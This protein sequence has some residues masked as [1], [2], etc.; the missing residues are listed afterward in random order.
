[1]KKRL[2]T[3]LA[4]TFGLS[5][6]VWI[7]AGFITGAV[8]DVNSS[9]IMLAIV[10]VSMFFPLVGALAAN[11]VV[12]ETER[13]DLGFKPRIRENVRSYVMAWLVP[14]ALA[15]AGSV[16]FFLVFPQLFDRS[17]TTLKAMLAAEGIPE[18]QLAMVLVGTLV[19]ALTV[20]PLVNCIP[21]LGEETGWRGMLFPTL[22]ECMPERVAVLVSGAIWGVWH[23]PI[24][25]MGHNY[26]TGYPGYPIAGILVMIV[27]CISLG[28]WL[29]WLRLRSG[30][31]WPCAI[32]HG[33]VNA[34]ANVG[35]VFCTA[36]AT[37]FGPSPLG[38]VAGI[39]AIVLAIACWRSLSSG[40]SREIDA[41]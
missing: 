40:R 36:G 6:G 15:L 23:A 39:P 29:S 10:A 26:G 28:C 1:M 25:A 19:S 13:I 24:I 16:V 27:A 30:S 31:V 17:A 9:P 22:C 18:D 33:A 7:P 35:S 21:A 3:F 8:H 34:S 5:W 32:A 4:V 20:G 37:L 2:A 41:C 12:P 38:L 14:A 11:A